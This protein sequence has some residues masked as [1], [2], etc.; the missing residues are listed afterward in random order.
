M[1]DNGW[2]EKG[3]ILSRTNTMSADKYSYDSGIWLARQN[4]NF[5]DIPEPAIYNPPLDSK[6][7][8]LKKLKNEASWLSKV[9]NEAS[10]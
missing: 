8:N 1:H 5:Q 2:N 9:Q 3:E 6:E 10:L 7:Y 4:K